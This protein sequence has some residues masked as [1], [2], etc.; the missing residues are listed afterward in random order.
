[1]LDD[2]LIASLRQGTITTSI[3]RDVDTD[4]PAVFVSR[5]TDRKTRCVSLGCVALSD[6]V[7][8]GEGVPM[9]VVVV[10]RRPPGCPPAF[11]GFRFPQE[12]I[13]LAVRWFLRFGLLSYRD[14][15]ELLAERGIEVDHVACLGLPT[16]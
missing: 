5:S 7:P 14:L 13:V 16:R 10:S 3:A 6:R 11:T 9:N 12:V 2:E 15:E 4:S 8:G 1:M